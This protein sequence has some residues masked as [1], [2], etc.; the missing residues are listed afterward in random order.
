MTFCFAVKNQFLRG[1]EWEQVLGSGQ[2]TEGRCLAKRKCGEWEGNSRFS[3]I[4]Y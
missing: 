4:R 2:P 1:R 3:F